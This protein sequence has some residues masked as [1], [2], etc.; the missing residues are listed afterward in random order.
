MRPFP[1]SQFYSPLAVSDI[2]IS[3]TNRL[4]WATEPPEML[5]FIGSTVTSDSQA[6][7]GCEREKITGI[8][9]GEEGS[10]PCFRTFGMPADSFFEA[11]DLR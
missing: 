10:L 4:N 9:R 7:D 1:Q 11:R 6:R 8:D 3:I 2:R 5:M